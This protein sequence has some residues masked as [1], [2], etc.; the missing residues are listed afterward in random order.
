MERS[1][2][3][4]ARRL[5]RVPLV[6]VTLGIIAEVLIRMHYDIRDK[7]PYRV[8]RTLNMDDRVSSIDGPAT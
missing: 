1:T 5:R 7:T 3:V 4:P 6:A 8:R 2:R